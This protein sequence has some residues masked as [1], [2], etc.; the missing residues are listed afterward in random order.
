MSGDLFLSASLF[1]STSLSA[2]PHL[3]TWLCVLIILPS[4]ACFRTIL[5]MTGDQASHQ[6]ISES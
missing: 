3:K 2:S 5:E 6:D 1:L 4:Q